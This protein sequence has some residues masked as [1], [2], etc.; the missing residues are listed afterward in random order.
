[1]HYGAWI[2]I[3]IILISGFA[4]MV[5]QT[6]AAHRL[7]REYPALLSQLMQAT[8]LCE[9]H[10]EAATN[11]NNEVKVFASN[12][13]VAAHATHEPRQMQGLQ[14]EQSTPQDHQQAHSRAHHQGQEACGYCNL[15]AHSPF[16][17]STLP[18]LI[19][20]T[21][22]HHTYMAA[23]GAAFRPRTVAAASRPQPP[24]LP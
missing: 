11:D 2:G 20:A 5:S 3:L 1:M 7:T 14:R 8:P 24:P 10:S 9:L 18:Q 4:P 15:F 17:V 12:A 13:G 23:L 16:L 22:I 19:A 21:Q 6:L